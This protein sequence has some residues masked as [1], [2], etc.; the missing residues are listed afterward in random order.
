METQQNLGSPMTSVPLG[1]ILPY[2]LTI[3]SR[4]EGWLPCDGSSVHAA[5]PLYHH[6]HHTPKLNGLTLIGTGTALSGTTY[7]LKDQN[8]EEK[9]TLVEQEI[10]AHTHTIYSSQGG[11]G[12]LGIGLEPKSGSYVPFCMGTL[13][14]TVY[15]TGATDGYGSS[16]AHNNMQP[17]YAINFIIF[18]GFKPQPPPPPAS[19]I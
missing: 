14:Q 19:T 15:G 10:P 17:Y 13:N 9:H 3:E 12:N 8:G 4:P 11:F 5:Y 18:A 2:A 16:G 1:T 6:M 7:N